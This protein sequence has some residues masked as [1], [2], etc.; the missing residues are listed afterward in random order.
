V[1]ALHSAGTQSCCISGATH[2]TVITSP[3][4]CSSFY[5]STGDG[6][7]KIIRPNSTNDSIYDFC[8]GTWE[9]EVEANCKYV[10]CANQTITGGIEFFTQDLNFPT[11]V[12]GN[13]LGSSF[14]I[15]GC[16]IGQYASG[17]TYH[18]S[19]REF[20]EMYKYTGSNGV[21][22]AYCRDFICNLVGYSSDPT[23][24][25]TGRGF[26][27]LLSGRPMLIASQRLGILNCSTVCTCTL[28][29]FNINIEYLKMGCRFFG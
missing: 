8:S 25:G 3:N 15:K 18:K 13:S 4:I 20:I 6:C 28:Y 5:Y 7:Y 22:A 11:L 27:C 21:C 1:P 26:I 23:N 17:T 29:G 10:S 14:I 24:F 19:Y 16:V 12:C 9:Y 2:C